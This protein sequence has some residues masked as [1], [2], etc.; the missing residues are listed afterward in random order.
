MIEIVYLIGCLISF[1]ILIIML[2]KHG[3]ITAYDLFV[4]FFGT[5]LS[6]VFILF[7]LFVYIGDSLENLEGIVIWKRKSKKK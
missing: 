4:L 7:T 6:W 5:L 2:L 3:T 1:A